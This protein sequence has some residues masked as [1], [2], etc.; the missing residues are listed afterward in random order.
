MAS[1]NFTEPDRA[2]L[3][4]K[5]LFPDRAVIIISPCKPLLPT[6]YLIFNDFNAL[7]ANILFSIFVNTLKENYCFFYEPF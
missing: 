5:N 2:G 6:N 3:T 7:Y 4:H 1:K